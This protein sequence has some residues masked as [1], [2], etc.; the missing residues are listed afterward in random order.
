MESLVNPPIGVAGIEPA[1]LASQKRCA[2]SALHPGE[3]ILIQDAQ[4]VKNEIPHS[5][6]DQDAQ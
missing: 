2:T 4:I 1:T 5:F 6:D 3:S